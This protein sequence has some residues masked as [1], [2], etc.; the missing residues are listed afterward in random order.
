MRIWLTILLGCVV[1][2]RA[3]TSEDVWQDEVGQVSAQGHILTK[4]NWNVLP[5]HHNII[6]LIRL[7]KK[8]FILGNQLGGR[9]AVAAL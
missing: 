1:P 7:L 2:S 6:R 3:A 8:L 9:A 5:V 4:E